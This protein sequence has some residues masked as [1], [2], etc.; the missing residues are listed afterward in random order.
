MGDNNFR[1]T[2]H[3]VAGVEKFK[4][5]KASVSR[6]NQ[7]IKHSFFIEATAIIESLIS[8]R[9]ES[10]LG[11][12]SKEPI[13]LDTLGKLLASLSK[14]ETDIILKEIMNKNIKSWSRDRNK[15]IHQIA[16]IEIGKMKDWDDFL[17]LAEI[18]ANEGKKIFDSYNKQ[19]KKNRVKKIF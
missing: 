8:D 16:K 15:V 14:V 4:I 12:L 2:I 13:H 5:I 19:L 10:R 3:D 7:A 11:E 1:A 18:T 9:L 17:K 6:F